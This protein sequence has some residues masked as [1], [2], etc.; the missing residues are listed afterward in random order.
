MAKPKTKSIKQDKIS[1]YGL[2]SPWDTD[3]GS[4]DLPKGMSQ[5]GVGT[6][7]GTGKKNNMGKLRDM[8]GV[9]PVSQSKLSLP[10]KKLA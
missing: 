10:P 4:Q 2:S 9:K 7:F 3:P 1:G 6:Y 8:S 5:P